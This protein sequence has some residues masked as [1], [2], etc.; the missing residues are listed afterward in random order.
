MN[1]KLHASV[2]HPHDT[3]DGEANF[4]SVIGNAKRLHIL[5][6]LAKGELSVGTLAE[7][8]TLSQSAT[9]QHLALLRDQDLVQPRRVSQTI[10]YSLRS[11]AVRIMLDTLAD[12]FGR[13]RHS[14]LAVACAEDRHLDAA[15][16]RPAVLLSAVRQSDLPEK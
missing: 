8:I 5:H 12:I 11:D 16:Q 9:S 14:K 4:L 6:L 15:R 2:H 3:F 7:E 10:Y 13:C 1:E